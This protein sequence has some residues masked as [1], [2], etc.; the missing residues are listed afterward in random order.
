M[1]IGQSIGNIIGPLLYTPSEAPEYYRGL[2]W[3][4]IL[5]CVIS[6]LVAV[7]SMYLSRLNAHHSQNR[8]LAGKNAAIIDYSLF[9]P[10]E[11][12]RKR[13]TAAENGLY[14]DSAKDDTERKIGARA[15]DDLTDLQNDEF[16]FVF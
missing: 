13:R 16:I 15:F 10:E 5:Y 6:V 4:L 12:E 1:F 2:Y 7:T 9:A 8:V 14:D 11:A 3:N